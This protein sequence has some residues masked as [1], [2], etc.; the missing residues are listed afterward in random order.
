[1]KKSVIALL[2]F[3]VVV[4]SLTAIFLKARRARTTESSA[5]ESRYPVF[6]IHART[7]E[8]GG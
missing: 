4:G 1:M 2:T 7:R 5:P 8:S 6:A 3:V